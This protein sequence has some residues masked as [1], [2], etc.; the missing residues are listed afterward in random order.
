[1]Q[2]LRNWKKVLTAYNIYYN[3]Q[4]QDNTVHLFDEV[5][6]HYTLETQE[7]VMNLTSAGVSSGA[8]G[9]VIQE[10]SKFVGNSVSRAPSRQTVDILSEQKVAVVQKQLD[11][12]VGESDMTLY[13]DETSKFGKSYGVFAVTYTTKN[14]YLLG[15]R[16]MAS[17]SA[18]TTLDTFHEILEDINDVCS[19]REEKNEQ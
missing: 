3:V 18:K 7:C 15:L 6:G 5:S 2:K 1:M 9:K 4:D 8:V 17:N 11:S 16:E 14:T 10:V 12:L 13:T 19:L